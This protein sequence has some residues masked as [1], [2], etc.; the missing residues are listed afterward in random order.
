M[1]L[2]G[3]AIRQLHEAELRLALEFGRV[4][5]R[6]AGDPDVFHL[7]QMLAEQCRSQA[8]RLQPL[9]ER[10]GSSDPSGAPADSVTAAR[11]EPMDSRSDQPGLVLLS[12]LNLLY[13]LAQECWID[14]TIVRQAAQAKRDRELL[15][16]VDSCLEKT[17]VQSKWLKTR[18]KATAPQAL[19]VG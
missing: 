4:A 16:T 18:I 14:A 12:D 8:E 3:D 11:S 9:A 5:E 10:S 7:C 2:L 19:T 1:T 6:H 13:L 17:T 15:E